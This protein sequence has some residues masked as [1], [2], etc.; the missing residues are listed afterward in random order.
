MYDDVSSHFEGVGPIPQIENI[1]QGHAHTELDS[2][3]PPV[4]GDDSIISQATHHP[5]HITMNELSHTKVPL[6]KMSQDDPLYPS[7]N[8]QV[9]SDNNNLGESNMF[10]EKIINNQ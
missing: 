5:P 3:N 6:V 1:T 9:D 8:Y 2:L 10:K 4:P 7:S